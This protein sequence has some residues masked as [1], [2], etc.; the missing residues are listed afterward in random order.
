MFVDLGG[1]LRW[2]FALVVACGIVLLGCVC[3]FLGCMGDLQLLVDFFLCFYLPVSLS[4]LLWIV[5]GFIF[6]DE[7]FVD[8]LDGLKCFFGV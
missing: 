1:L 6:V 3:G 5:G 8:C 2:N 7:L 4:G